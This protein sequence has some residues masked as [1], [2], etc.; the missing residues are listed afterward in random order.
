MDAA[1]PIGFRRGRGEWQRDLPALLGWARENGFASLDL[2]GG[3]G[4]ADEAAQVAAAGLTVGS[5]DL[6]DGYG[7][8][9]LLSADPGT[10]AA[11]VAA[12]RARIA[13][14]AA[15]GV[16]HFFAVMVPEDPARP[17]RENFASML[18]SYAALVPALEAAGARVIVE[19]WPGPGC[20]CCTPETCRALLRALP[21]AALG[22]CY[23][24][25]HLV[26]TG[27]DAGRFLREFADR[28]YHVH[29][30]DTRLADA[31]ALYEYGREQPATFTD[32]PRWSG[33]AWRYVIPG[34]GATDWP[35]TLR[36]L[37]AAGYAGGISVELEDLDFHGR[38]E[39]EKRGLL[40]A[41]DFLAG[42]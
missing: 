16:R 6:C 5:V 11:A 7:F 24:P 12:A 17:R 30:K 37:A 15:M 35:E 40:L 34:R 20:L 26:R 9:A 25:S 2:A 31:D 10:R 3:P 1:F 23:D 41:R 21:A 19:G 18:D 28:V 27:I 4:V 42:C 38:E 32:A 39:S 14:C 33:P 8:G 36:T 29:G 13:A 22:L